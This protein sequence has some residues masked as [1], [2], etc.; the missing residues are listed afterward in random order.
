MGEE[1][2]GPLYYLKNVK[3][4]MFD[5]FPAGRCQPDDDLD[6]IENMLQVI[7]TI[8]LWTIPL[9]ILLKDFEFLIQSNF[10]FFFYLSIRCFISFLFVLFG[11]V[12]F[13][14]GSRKEFSHSSRSLGILLKNSE[15]FLPLVGA[16]SLASCWNSLWVGRSL[17]LKSW[18]CS[19]AIDSWGWFKLILAWWPP[20]IVESMI[21]VDIAWL[22]D[23]S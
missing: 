3:C 23:R 15:A 18:L 4:Y 7:S 1:S 16:D 9:K 5:E 20:L 6:V 10:I 13:W 11:F 22:I 14:R 12:W 2:R 8:Q 19:S 21:E 17:S